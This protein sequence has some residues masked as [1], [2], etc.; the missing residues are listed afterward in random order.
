MGNKLLS[1]KSKA[2]YEQELPH[3]SL[4]KGEVSYLPTEL[5][6]VEVL[7]TVDGLH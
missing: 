5:L 3:S 6:L 1:S 7:V 2:F 4:S